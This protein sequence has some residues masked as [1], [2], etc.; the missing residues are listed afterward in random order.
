MRKQEHDTAASQTGSLD[1]SPSKLTR[2]H[3]G[4]ATPII[5]TGDDVI[6]GGRTGIVGNNQQTS[7]QS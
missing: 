7:D 3:S 1:Q 6:G 4:S 2:R 5:S